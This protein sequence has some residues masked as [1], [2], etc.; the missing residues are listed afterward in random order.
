[1]RFIVSADWHL[2][3]DRPRCRV[4]EDWIG[5]QRRAL[6]QLETC[7]EKY[8]CDLVVVGDLFHRSTEFRMVRLVQSLAYRL[9]VRNLKLYYLAGNHDLLYHSTANLDRS[10]IGLL[11]STNNC[12]Y[13]SDLAI[14][15]VSA[16]NF[17]EECDDSK[18]HLFIHTLCF[19]DMKSMPPN[20]NAVYAKDLLE[21]H[22]NAKW[23]F[24]GDY[25]HSFH[26]E[27]NGRHVV[28][29]GCLIRQAVDMKDYRCGAYFVDTDGNV[30]EFLP[31][32]DDADMV[33]DAYIVD[34]KVR[35]ERIGE[36]VDKLKG[37]KAVSLDFADNVEKAL[38][39]SGLDDAVKDMVNL[40]ME[41]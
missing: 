31:I 10:A 8:D 19:P 12:F 27:W 36:F 11:E 9:S 3:E 18:E 28:N 34:E 20:V 25:H 13:I 2:R 32:E 21:E 7:C 37:T 5:V 14:Y 6:E 29:S 40:L 24:T 26:Y 23:I 15:S 16:P 35:D 4:D 39:S 22:P 33:D 38:A 17:D 30:V 1:M 41:G